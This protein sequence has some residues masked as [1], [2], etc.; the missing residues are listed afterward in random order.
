[1]DDTR[2][3]RNE[4]DGDVVDDCDD[5]VDDGVDV[6]VD[7]VNIGDVVAA[8]DVAGGRLDRVLSAYDIG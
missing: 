1:M 4:V 3:P 8:D 6:D 2:F 7:D 5:D